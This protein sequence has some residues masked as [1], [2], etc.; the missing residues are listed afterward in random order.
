MDKKI[1]L[2]FSVIV[3]ALFLAMI[4]VSDQAKTNGFVNGY[5]CAFENQNQKLRENYLR[6]YEYQPT[7]FC[8]EFNEWF[9]K[10]NAENYKSF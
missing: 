8:R 5:V 10:L 2:L 3:V 7:E 1:L 9:D 6:V 4:V